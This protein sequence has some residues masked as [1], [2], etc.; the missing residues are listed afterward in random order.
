MADSTPVATP[1]GDDNTT[2]KI[3]VGV[4]AALA[5]AAGGYYF[6]SQK[7]P[8]KSGGAASGETSDTKEQKTDSKED[9][10]SDTESKSPASDTKASSDTPVRTDFDGQYNYQKRSGVWWT[11]LKSKPTAWVSLAAD[12]WAAARAKLDAAYPNG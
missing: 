8:A 11:A 1:D 10:S 6:Y 12:K 7:K 2:L 5:L 3:V 9:K 4:L